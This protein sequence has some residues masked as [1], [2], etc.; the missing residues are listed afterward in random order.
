MK[1]LLVLLTLIVS[2][3]INSLA[4][5]PVITCSGDLY[6]IPGAMTKDGKTYMVDVSNDRATITIYDGNFNVVRKITDPTAGM[7]VSQ[8]TVTMTCKYDGDLMEPITE[9]TVENDQT[10]EIT[11]SSSI[12][13]FEM[14]SDNNDYH[15]RAVYVTQTLFDDDDE[16]EYL[17][18]K[19]AI[20]PIDVKYS[21]YEKEHPRPS[22]GPTTDVVYGDD[23]IDRIIKETG[24][25]SIT[26]T[27]DEERGKIVFLLGKTET[28]GG[29]YTEGMEIV[30][31]DGTVKSTL[32]NTNYI[33]SA[34]YFRGKCYIQ[35]YD[36]DGNKVLYQL[37][38]KTVESIGMGGV[39]KQGD[40]NGDG[41]VTITDAVSVVNI[42]LN[43][44]NAQAAPAKEDETK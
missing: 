35:G 25:N 4:Q 26:T 30:S 37:G 2:F 3:S 31:S 29:T 27:W 41:E 13:H 17:R 34:Y 43:G 38:D 11:K 24:A 8:R 14:Y 22:S 21:D 16:F 9:W 6:F 23:V 44:S 15:S 19:V 18:Q 7:L 39:A 32:P 42:I 5:E 40:V 1:R 20:I 12:A 28:Y 33:S 36:T 10:N